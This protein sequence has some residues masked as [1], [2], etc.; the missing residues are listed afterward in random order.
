MQGAQ[1]AARWRRQYGEDDGPFTKGL[2]K[3][4]PFK[5]YLAT[6]PRVREKLKLKPFGIRIE[7][8][9]FCAETFEF[10]HRDFDVANLLEFVRLAHLMSGDE[11]R[12]LMPRW[13]LVDLVLMPSG[14]LLALA[15][16]DQVVYQA[17]KLERSDGSW[18]GG[19]NRRHAARLR[20]L[21]QA[22]QDRGYE[23]PLPVAGYAALPTLVPGTWVGGSLWWSLVPGCGLGYSVRRI[24]L[25]CYK[26]TR[27]IGVTQFGDRR[28]LRAQRG[29]GPLRVTHAR[30]A[31]HPNRH[32]FVYEV[33]LTKLDKKGRPAKLVESPPD[34]ESIDSDA[35]A[36]E[37]HLS[38]ID[39]A[40]QSGDACYIIP[41]APGS[42]PDSLPIIFTEKL[43]VPGQPVAPVRPLA[44]SPRI[45]EDCEGEEFF[46]PGI[47]NG[48]YQPYVI[49]NDIMLDKLQLEPFG[50]DIGRIDLCAPTFDFGTGTF[51]VTHLLNL[52][53]QAIAQSYAESG[54]GMPMWAMVEL[55]LMPSAVLFVLADKRHVADTAR[56]LAEEPVI[57]S[58]QGRLIPLA[59]DDRNRLRNANSLR[60]LLDSAAKHGYEGPLPVAGYAAAPTPESHRWVGWS[61]W[62]LVPGCRLG[63]TVKRLGIAC[64][65]V[66]KQS[67]VIQ[68]RMARG[69]DVIAKFGMLRITTADVR[70]HPD[71]PAFIYQIDVSK[72][73]HDGSPAP[74]CAFSKA[75]WHFD[76]DSD[77]LY[78]D[79][80]RLKYWIKRG[81]QFYLV[82]R[83][84]GRVTSPVISVYQQTP[85]DSW[86]VTRAKLMVQGIKEWIVSWRRYRYTTARHEL[87]HRIE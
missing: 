52:L 38:R 28:A 68:Y 77:E 11:R 50:I 86:L 84:A 51:D 81:T 63:Y 35:P 83:P 72:L 5:L 12:R 32:T 42:P 37:S 7:P 56:E 60:V 76:P 27:E 2:A 19:D 57:D 70:P 17:R 30:L 40:V 48:M 49:S 34:A 36:F 43:V 3:G 29:F 82:P 25:G 6:N 62:S 13:M 24:A 4:E 47:R 15:G 58:R 87:K 1:L 65:D 59:E 26:A 10:D 41:P 67:A 53:S 79:V 74:E 64:Y 80:A 14:V 78:R 54:L 18:A 71:P 20:D 33:D 46:T 16:Q 39:N 21:L 61:L 85:W 44:H 23:G 31:V 22:A 9:D 66:R 45:V 69:L 55:A 73:P 8:I 75:K